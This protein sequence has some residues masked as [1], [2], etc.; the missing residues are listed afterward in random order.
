MKKSFIIL[1]IFSF[2]NLVFSQDYE[3]KILTYRDSINEVFG[4]PEQSILKESDL[5][6]FQG[7]HFY[8]VDEDFE[9]KAKFKRIRNGKTFKMKTSTD[10]LPTYRPYGLLKFKINGVK[11]TLTVYQ[12]IELSKNKE[13]SDYLFIPFTDLT[14]GDESYGGGR[15]LD[16]KISDLSRATIDFNYCYNPYCAYND[17]YSCPIPPS[18]NHLEIAINA[19]VKKWH[20]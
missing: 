3:S 18:E 14:S 2:Q 12:N 17:T 15:Y 16:I 19:G 1:F 6:D 4:D 7:L 11:E 10:R 5:Q 13:Y 9:V 8:E 20:D